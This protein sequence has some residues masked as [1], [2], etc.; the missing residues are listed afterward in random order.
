MAGV[1]STA[2]LAHTDT[3]WV[4]SMSVPT[5]TALEL[6][7]AIQTLIQSVSSL[8]ARL[9]ASPQVVLAALDKPRN[10]QSKGSTGDIVTDTGGY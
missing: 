1:E 10:I 6:L 3:A 4:G 2:G 9:P 7:Q 5:Q 8:P